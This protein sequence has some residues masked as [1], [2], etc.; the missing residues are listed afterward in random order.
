MDEEEE[1]AIS[2][3]VFQWTQMM[4]FQHSLSINKREQMASLIIARKG[5]KKLSELIKKTFN[6]RMPKTIWQLPRLR[7]FWPHFRKF[8]YPVQWLENFRMSKNTFFYLHS[9]LRD[10]LKP[11]F[12]FLQPLRAVE[13]DEQLAICIYYLAGTSEYREVGNAFGYHKST[14]CKFVRRV[15]NQIVK[16]L[17]PDWIKMPDLEEC[18][19]IASEFE[20]LCNIPQIILATD[21]CHIPIKPSME[22]HADFFNRKGWPSLV[23]QGTV[24]SKAWLFKNYS[25]VKIF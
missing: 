20:G 22:G 24:D 15:C 13:S 4:M 12:N 8:A 14:I 19:D 23:L 10:R 18:K 6:F 17:M 25:R 9:L 3:M 16:V 21:G 1:L 11:A 7:Q 5:K 2:F